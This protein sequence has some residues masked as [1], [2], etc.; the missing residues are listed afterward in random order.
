MKNY[1]STDISLV[2]LPVAT[3]CLL[4]AIFLAPVFKQ[5]LKRMLPGKTSVL[6]RI[7]IG[8]FIIYLA[9]V[10][11][12]FITLIRILHENGAFFFSPLLR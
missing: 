12:C 11:Y 10:C 1:F 7:L 2:L 6:I 4:L 5:K 3:G 8:I 9:S